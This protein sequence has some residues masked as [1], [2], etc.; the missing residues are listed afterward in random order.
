MMLQSM[1]KAI[2]GVEDPE[3][4]EEGCKYHVHGEEEGCYKIRHENMNIKEVI[5]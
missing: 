5:E 3:T 2:C 1:L 4:E